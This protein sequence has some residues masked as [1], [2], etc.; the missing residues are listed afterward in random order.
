M[1]MEPTHIYSRVPD[2]VLT[3]VYNLVELRV[4]SSVGILDHS[5]IFI[6][7]VLENLFFT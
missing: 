2:L 1:V 5:A 3:D 4:G 6:V 7:F